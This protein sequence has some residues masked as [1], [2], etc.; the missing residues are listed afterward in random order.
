MQIEPYLFFEDRCEEA[1]EFYR[2][3]SACSLTASAWGG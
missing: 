2:R 3:A 1:V